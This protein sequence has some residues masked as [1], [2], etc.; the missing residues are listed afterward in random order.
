M[1]DFGNE[2]EYKDDDVF[3]LTPKGLII[4]RLLGNVE[5]P[6]GLGEEIWDGL[7]GMCMRRVK[8][9]DPDNVMEYAAIVFD[10]GGGHIIGVNKE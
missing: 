10:G 6:M 1:D 2:T 3:R 9:E 4:A 5:D 8:E 7:Q